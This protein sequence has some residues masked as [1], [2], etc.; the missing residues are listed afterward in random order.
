MA[1]VFSHAAKVIV[2]LG[3]ADQYT[4]AAFELAKTVGT[5]IPIVKQ[6]SGSNRATDPDDAR[7]LT[8]SAKLNIAAAS[9]WLALRYV[10]ERPWFARP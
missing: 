5:Q 9:E 8:Y 10:P 4:S 2:W 7:S 6:E 1:I 3:D